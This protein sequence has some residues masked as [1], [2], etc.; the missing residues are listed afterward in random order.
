MF[1][2]IF[3]FILSILAT[4]C[5]ATLIMTCLHYLLGHRWNW[6]WFAKNHITCHHAHYLRDNLTSNKYIPDEKNNTPYLMIP[7]GIIFPFAYLF[8][9]RDLFLV[10]LATIIMIFIAH[11]YLHGHYH[12]KDTWLNRFAWFRWKQQ[13]HFVHHRNMGTNFGVIEFFWDKL[14]GTYCSPLKNDTIKRG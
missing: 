14:F 8:L 10:C 4:Y 9:P 2:K 7:V 3:S 11:V 1:I 13:L 6:C 12:L 5:F